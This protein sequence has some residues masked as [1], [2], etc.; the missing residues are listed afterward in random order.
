LR[1][2]VA[3]PAVSRGTALVAGLGRFRRTARRALI[4]VLSDFL[5]AEP[6]GV[7]RRVS[8]RHQVIALRLVDPRE[9]SLPDA[10]LLDLEESEERTRRLVDASSRRVRA[11]YAQAASER[12]TAFR[13]WCAAAGISGHEIS[14][15]EDPIGPLIRLFAGRA[16]RR[17]IP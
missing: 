3:T 4:V 14:T 6:V 12:R 13:R 17:G 10:G 8:R 5:S 7:W 11:A 15:V 16:T 1:A 2:L 9:E